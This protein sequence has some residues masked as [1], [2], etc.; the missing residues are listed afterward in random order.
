MD[1]P[2]HRSNVYVPNVIGVISFDF[3]ILDKK[4]NNNKKT[5]SV[6]HCSDMINETYWDKLQ[7]PVLNRLMDWIIFLEAPQKQEK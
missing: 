7:K 3:Y 1:T 5:G 2:C 4:K 6:K